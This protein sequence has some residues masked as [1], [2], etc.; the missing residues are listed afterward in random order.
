MGTWEQSVAK[1]YFTRVSRV[2]TNWEQT[3]NYGYRKAADM[4]P[5]E[6]W[7]ILYANRN[8]GSGSYALIGERVF[9][10]SGFRMTS[11]AVRRFYYRWGKGDNMPKVRPAQKPHPRVAPTTS[12]T[13]CWRCA[14]SVPNNLTGTGCPWSIFFR[15]IEGWKAE[16]HP[17]RMVGKNIVK[18][19]YTVIE[20]PMFVEDISEEME[21]ELM[22]SRKNRKKR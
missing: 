11:N 9:R 12:H 1:P 5:D 14:N 8:L 19:T 21:R 17:A 15:P 2:P 3:G 4:I 16:Y 13:L 10:E 6:A 18:E 7:K 20:C 22:F